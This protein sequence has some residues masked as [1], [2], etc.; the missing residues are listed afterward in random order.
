MAIFHYYLTLIRG[1]EKIHGRYTCNKCVTVTSFT[2]LVAKRNN[3]Y[4]NHNKSYQLN[5]RWEY[6]ST[7]ET[8]L[9][10]VGG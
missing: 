6:T 5:P 1:Q 2:F 10:R 8:A 4:Q 3:K 7:H 9:S